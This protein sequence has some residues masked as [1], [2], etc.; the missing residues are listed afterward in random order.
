MYMFKDTHA[1][2][3]PFT[4]G[5]EPTNRWRQAKT[6]MKTKIR[7][8]IFFFFFS[9]RLHSAYLLGHKDTSCLL[10]GNTACKQANSSWQLLTSKFFACLVSFCFSHL[11]ASGKLFHPESKNMISFWC[12]D[13]RT[14]WKAYRIS[15][16]SGSQ[17][18]A[19][20][21]LHWGLLKSL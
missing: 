5:V 6:K 1:L 19:M 3:A 11:K 16:S 7:F 2:M 17:W 12:L 20:S 21:Y 18:K 15:V 8:Q 9:P 13:C 10:V 4:G 14:E